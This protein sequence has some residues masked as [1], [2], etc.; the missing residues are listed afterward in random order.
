MSD[1]QRAHMETRLAVLIQDVPES[2]RRDD[3]EEEAQ[4]PRF[5][6]VSVL[7]APTAKQDQQ[8]VQSVDLEN[9]VWQGQDLAATVQQVDTVAICQPA[10]LPP[11]F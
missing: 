11:V 2:V 5:V 1:V 8:N 6:R 3:S 9:T 10:T 4:R 7:L